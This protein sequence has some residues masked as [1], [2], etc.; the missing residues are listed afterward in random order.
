MEPLKAVLDQ[1][2]EVSVLLLASGFFYWWTV[3][4]Y[5]PVRL[6]HSLSYGTVR[7]IECSVCMEVRLKHAD[8]RTLTMQS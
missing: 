3:C 8:Y 6:I 4:L 2:S 1:Q 5:G 7:L